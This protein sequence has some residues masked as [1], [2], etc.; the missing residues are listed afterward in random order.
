M[1]ARLSE[2]PIFFAISPHAMQQQRNNLAHRKGPQR[3]LTQCIRWMEKAID[4]CFRKEGVA[5]SVIPTVDKAETCVALMPPSGIRC[6]RIAK[7]GVYPYYTLAIPLASHCA[8]ISALILFP[9]IASYCYLFRLFI[10]PCLLSPNHIGRILRQCASRKRSGVLLP[11]FVCFPALY[12]SIHP[13]FVHSA[14]IGCRHR[15]CRP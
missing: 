6:D 1:Q 4:F 11:A 8:I 3:T 14:C 13:P 9:P 7:R 2:S 12:A 15:L 5:E 10:F